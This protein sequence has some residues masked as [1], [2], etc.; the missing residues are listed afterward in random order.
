MTVYLDTSVVLRVLLRQAKPL[1]EWRTWERAYTSELLGL[2]AR[3]AF[4]RIRLEGAVDVDDLIEL[5]RQLGIVEEAVAIVGLTRTLLRRAA[6]P[7]AL[8]VRTLDAIHLVSAL[9]LEAIGA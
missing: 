2:E 9:G 4:D 1:R 3:R 7:M 5:Q 6:M 8:A